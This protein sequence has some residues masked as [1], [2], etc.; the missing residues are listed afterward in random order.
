MPML[1]EHF[2]ILS[3]NFFPPQPHWYT[4]YEPQYNSLQ[5]EVLHRLSHLSGDSTLELV[6]RILGVDLMSDEFMYMLYRELRR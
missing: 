5:L 3:H 4:S 6:Q 1:P 2:E